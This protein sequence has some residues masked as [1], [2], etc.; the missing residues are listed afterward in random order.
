MIVFNGTEAFEISSIANIEEEFRH[1][2][3]ESQQLPYVQ[4]QREKDGS[5][6]CK[7]GY[8]SLDGIHKEENEDIQIG[9][10]LISMID[11]SQEIHKENMW[12]NAEYYIDYH[13][14]IIIYLDSN[15]QNR[16]EFYSTDSV[17]YKNGKIISKSNNSII[18]FFTYIVPQ[19][20]NAIDSGIPSSELNMEYYYQKYRDGGRDYASYETNPYSISL[21]YAL[22]LIYSLQVRIENIKPHAYSDD[23]VTC[24]ATFE[25][26]KGIIYNAYIAH[27]FAKIINASIS[28]QHG[29]NQ[30]VLYSA[31]LYKLPNYLKYDVESLRRYILRKLYIGI[32]LNYEQDK[33]EEGFCHCGSIREC[34]DIEQNET[35]RSVLNFILGIK[36][37]RFEDGENRVGRD[38]RGWTEFTVLFPT[39]YGFVPSKFMLELIDNTLDIKLER[40]DENLCYYHRYKTEAEYIAGMAWRRDFGSYEL[41][42]NYLHSLLKKI[43]PMISSKD[44]LDRLIEK[45][46]G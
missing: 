27:L 7:I 1:H 18:S 9:N 26:R 42:R 16:F 8:V 44:D 24:Y 29:D 13:Y 10:V 37:T 19:I 6:Y 25:G 11:V 14:S 41:Q 21:D 32:L 31:K 3:I 39:E 4:L 46:Q 15:Y 43:I 20:N 35:I 30:N 34:K 23:D 2:S 28:K 17:T 33:A 22:D 12:I 36:A 38:D 45:K 40:Q 5:L